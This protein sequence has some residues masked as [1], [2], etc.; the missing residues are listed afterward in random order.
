MTS[1][2]P[3]RRSASARLTSRGAGRSGGRATRGESGR[4]P[5]FVPVADGRQT[6]PGRMRKGESPKE[7]GER[8]RARIAEAV[9]DLLAESELPPTANEVASRAGVSVRLVFHHF[10]DM[11]ALYRAVSRTQFDRH[12][13]GLRP[14]PGEL[15]IDRRIDRTVQQR[16][17]LF[18]AIGPVRRNAVL[19]AV[20]HE[21][22]A[23]G[24]DH[25]NTFLRTLLEETFADE[26]QAAGRERRELLAALEAAA[27]W[28]TWERLR[29]SQRLTNAAARRVVARTLH[30]LLTA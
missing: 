23:K 2:V 28:E 27:S 15:P 19:L 24:F 13:R 11:D 1:Q 25:S 14:V 10:E 9:I 30:A 5:S 17:K 26:L 29:R 12:W 22:V 16:A 7:R 8:T 6:G 4:R 20:R 21:E 3:A 18:E